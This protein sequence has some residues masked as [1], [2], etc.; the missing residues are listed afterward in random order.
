MMLTRALRGSAI[1]LVVLA[2]VGVP[3]LALRSDT[4]LSRPAAAEPVQTEH[5][6]DDTVGMPD[7]VRERHC[8]RIQHMYWVIQG[9]GG[10]GNSDEISGPTADELVERAEVFDC[11][12][13]SGPPADWSPPEGPPY[14]WAWGKW[15]KPERGQGNGQGNGNAGP[16]WASAGDGPPWGPPPGAGKGE[17]D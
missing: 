2:L 10:P 6:T 4:P 16:K 15:Q 17:D 3:A 8:D 9:G 14:G 13:A 1:A 12:L 11:A 5:E 7:W